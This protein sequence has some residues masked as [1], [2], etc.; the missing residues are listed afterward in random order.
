M[1]PPLEGD[2]LAVL[3]GAMWAVVQELAIAGRFEAGP[4]RLGDGPGAAA[5][6]G[7]FRSRVVQQPAVAPPQQQA[8]GLHS[9]AASHSRSSSWNPAAFTRSTTEYLSVALSGHRQL[10]TPRPVLHTIG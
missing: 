7:P 4:L 3:G 9:F 5:T 6:P 2:G 10:S 8:G 1:A